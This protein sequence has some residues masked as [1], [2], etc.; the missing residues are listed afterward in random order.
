MM[1]KPMLWTHSLPTRPSR[2]V[3][4]IWTRSS[5]WLWRPASPRLLSHDRHRG[6]LGLSLILLVALSPTAA[7]AAT[8]FTLPPGLQ[9]T[10][11][12]CLAEAQRL[13]PD[14]LGAKDH[15]VACLID[16]RKQLSQTCRTI[17]D[18]AVSLLHGGD[19][20]LDLRALKKR[21]GHLKIPGIAPAP[22]PSSGR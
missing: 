10:A 18:Q 6:G 13:C 15:G 9:R 14:M 19:V 8:R 21:A 11:L 22:A 3:G 16:K 1:Q 7:P 4:R 20:H 12:V 17:A 5:L 2:K